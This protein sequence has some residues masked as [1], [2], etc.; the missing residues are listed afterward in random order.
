MKIELS[1]SEEMAKKDKEN[2]GHGGFP[3]LPHVCRNF[4][5]QPDTAWFPI[6]VCCRVCPGKLQ[7]VAVP[8][9]VLRGLLG[10][11]A[12]V[13][14]FVWWEQITLVQGSIRVLGP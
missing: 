10:Q 8:M 9:C 7:M 12:T 1:K 13:P 2:W 11:A 5:E 6:S 14:A 4:L 3:A